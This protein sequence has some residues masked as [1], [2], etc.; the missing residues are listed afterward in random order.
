MEN[1][2]IDLTSLA[3]LVH[4]STWNR[5][6]VGFAPTSSGQ[7]LCNVVLNSTALFKGCMLREGAMDF[8]FTLKKD[9]AD[10]L[11]FKFAYRGSDRKC[12]LYTIQGADMNPFEVATISLPSNMDDVNQFYFLKRFQYQF[13]IDTALGFKDGGVECVKHFINFESSKETYEAK[14]RI[15]VIV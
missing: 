11:A 15:Q 2:D 5:I 12:I 14:P 13:G 10:H 3:T 4:T 1:I 6:K 9:P 8:T 7:M